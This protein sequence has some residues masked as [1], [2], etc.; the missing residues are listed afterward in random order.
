MATKMESVG[1]LQKGSYIVLEG[2]ACRVVDMQVSR[3]G[4]HGH[5]KVRLTG[6]GIV[7][8]KK[9]IVVMPGHDNVDVPIIEKKS[10]Q[11]LS[12]H[13]NTT[14]VMDSESYET[15]DLAIPEELKAQVVEGATVLYWEILNDKVMKQIKGD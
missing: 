8:N 14:N 9:R 15:F 13:D 3:P 2:V 5:S 11:V 4:K 7:D 6:I 1:S 10:A 12:V